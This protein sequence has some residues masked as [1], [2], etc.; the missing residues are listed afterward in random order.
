M[1]RTTER[2]LTSRYFRAQGNYVG[3]RERRLVKRKMSYIRG[4]C[5]HITVV[6]ARAPTQVKR[7][8]KGEGFIRKHSQYL[9]NSLNTFLEDIRAKVGLKTY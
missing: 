2:R 9:M 5:C 4:Y 7:Y 6:Y 1:G 8:Y 3:S